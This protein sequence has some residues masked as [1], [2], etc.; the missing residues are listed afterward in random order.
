MSISSVKY[1]N[2]LKLVDKDGNDHA[3]IMQYNSG[4]VNY[5]SF[6]GD[7]QVISLTQGTP[8]TVEV[9]EL[10]NGLKLKLTIEHKSQN[11]G[12]DQYRHWYHFELHGYINNVEVTGSDILLPVVNDSAYVYSPYNS[13][14]LMDSVYVYYTGTYYNTQ[15]PTVVNDPAEMIAPYMV[16]WYKKDNLGYDDLI[17]N[18]DFNGGIQGHWDFL[19]GMPSC[20]SDSDY[21][22]IHNKMMQIGTGEDPFEIGEPGPD[23]EPE[24]D[25][26]APGGGDKPTGG[27][28]EPIDFPD[29]PSTDVIASGLVT[30]Y[31][32]DNTSLRSLAGVLW[33]NDFENTIKKILNDP[34][35]GIIG[36]SLIPFTPTVSGSENCRI[37][38]F[39]TEVSMPLVS[40]QWMTLDG[41]SLN[42]QES[43]QNALD[44]SPNTVVDLFIPF[45]GFRELKTEDVMA[46]TIS[47]KY[48]VDLLSGA[49]V[50]MVKCGDKVMYTY[51]CKLTYDIPLTGSNKAALYT[52]MINIAM[53]AIK[54]ASMGGALGAAGGAATSAIQTATSKQSQVD[55]SGSLASNT[56]DLGEFKPY[57][58]I[59]RP[60]QSMPKDFKQIKGYQSNITALLSSLTGYTEVDFIH[61]TGID[62]ATDTELKEIE[63]LLKEGVII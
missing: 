15:T 39:D 4:G 41:G 36:L 30:M 19:S 60:I 12:V 25:P 45:V 9:I 44:Y 21:N 52:G 14:P 40:A 2:R 7:R 49:A 33:G 46:K 28:G 18:L 54:G 37:G 57:V 63:S 1:A 50:A 43:W 34:F 10:K 35:D 11:I 29:L 6:P 8:T 23:P 26:S 42:I 20:L 51:P 31:N 56:G 58:V 47:L 27:T 32:P 53:S 55:R 48:N 61:L 5:I 38:N 17:G 22:D 13:F 24:P 16:I 62:G 3:G 59:H